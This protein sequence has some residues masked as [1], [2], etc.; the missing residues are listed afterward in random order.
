MLTKKI[1]LGSVSLDGY[2][3]RPELDVTQKQKIDKLV[4]EIETRMPLNIEQ[5]H[6][7]FLKSQQYP[8]INPFFLSVENSIV[9][10]GEEIQVPRFGVY[11]KSSEG[12]NPFSITFAIN[13]K[14][15][16]FN[17]NINLHQK[18][19]NPNLPRL[20][21]NFLIKATGFSNYLN[22]KTYKREDNLI[23]DYYKSLTKL[24]REVCKKHKKI[25]RFTLT[26]EFCGILPQ[27]IIKKFEKEE[28]I[29]DKQLYLIAEIKPK[30][31]DNLDLKDKDVLLVGVCNDKC[32][33]ID[34][35]HTTSIEDYV[36]KELTD[37][38]RREK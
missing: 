34:Y 9:Y 29:F 27:K 20:F 13:K 15:I 38:I 2:V 6:L 30:A 5:H 36:G 8:T 35:F 25:G 7:S 14:W 1:T 17:E 23:K 11:G 24:S 19:E 31:W 18:E 28:E 16:E 21:T 26:S 4:Q 33:L 10:R 22:H 37:Q 3:T 32:R 12:F